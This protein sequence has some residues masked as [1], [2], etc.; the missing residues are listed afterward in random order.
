MLKHNKEMQEY[1]TSHGIKC[2]V[3]RID[4]GSLKGTWRLYGKGQR[5]TVELAD[6]LTALG[7][8]DYDGKPFGEYSG[9]GGYF[10]VFVTL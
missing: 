2:Q 5:W 1:L 9:N 8:K 7:F 10:S 6:D 3:K 4:K